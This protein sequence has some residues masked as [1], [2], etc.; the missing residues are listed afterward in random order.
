MFSRRPRQVVVLIA[1]VILICAQTGCG[2]GTGP[3]PVGYAGE[4]TGTT[5][6]GTP[7]Q[8]SVSAT[9]TVTSITLVYRFSTECSGTLTYT[10]LALPIH[11]SNP[12]GLPTSD[13]LGFAYSTTNGASGTLIVGGFSSDRRSAS[14]RFALVDFGACDTVVGTWSATRR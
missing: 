7:V 3:S 6:S 9:E 10:G 14:G 2:G 8:F 11:T 13:Q 1:V 12:P 4:W 5:S